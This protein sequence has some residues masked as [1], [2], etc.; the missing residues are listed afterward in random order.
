MWLYKTLLEYRIMPEEAFGSDRVVA[1][2]YEVEDGK[3]LPSE[4]CL[5]LT[6]IK[7]EDVPAFNRDRTSARESEPCSRGLMDIPLEDVSDAG[8][9]VKKLGIEPLTRAEAAH[10]PYYKKVGEDWEIQEGIRFAEFTYHAEQRPGV[11]GALKRCAE[12]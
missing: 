11:V 6:I 3:Y 12:A 2:L 7:V 4:H 5:Y 9:F 10:I 8:R 1:Y